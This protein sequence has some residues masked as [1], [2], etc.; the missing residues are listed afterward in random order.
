MCR[1]C[2]GG[3]AAPNQRRPR[4]AE[5]KP[6]VGR[7]RAAQHGGMTTSFTLN[8]R[9]CQLS[10]EPDTPLLWALREA[11]GLTGTKFGCGVGD[12]GACTVQLDGTALRSCLMPLAGVQ[13][14]SVT[15]IEGLSSPEGRAL[16]DAW[17]A[18]QVPQCG[19]CQS[20]VLMAAEAL[21]REHRQPSEAQLAAALSNIC[22]CGT[23]PRMRSAFAAAADALQP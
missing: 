1:C 23:Y 6:L 12:C 3:C 5:R 8:G 13:A 10:D 17:V 18:H 14:R 19:Y 16:Q 21:L 4:T 22:R 2:W 15:T 11:C 20:G 7:P 9:P